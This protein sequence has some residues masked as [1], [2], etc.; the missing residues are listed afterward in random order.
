M[1]SDAPSLPQDASSSVDGP[2]CRVPCEP[3]EVERDELERLRGMSLDERGRLLAMVCR[4]AARL[5]RSRAAAGL[6]PPAEDPWPEST[7]K[8]LR[9]QAR[10]HAQ[11]R[12]S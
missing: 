11:S 8:F 10:Q 6:P 2:H 3:E 9:N 5:D 4:A 7:W 12:G 1:D